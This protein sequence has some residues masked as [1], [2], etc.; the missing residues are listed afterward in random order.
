MA[1]FSGRTQA[2]KRLAKRLGQ[3]GGEVY[4]EISDLLGDPPE[5]MALTPEIWNDI[6]LRY[7]G[8]LRPELEKIFLAALDELLDEISFALDFDMVNAAASD[9]A[10]TYT[11]ELVGGINN[12]SRTMVQQAVADFFDQG[13]SI[14][15]LRDKLSRTFG[16]VRAESIAVTEVTRAV[17]ESGKLMQKELDAQGVRTIPIHNTSND[18]KVCPICLPRD[19]Q[20]IT[21]GRY[22]PL[23]VRCRCWTSYQVI[24]DGE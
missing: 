5:L 18:E 10:R 17:T 15:D 20:P 2:E 8:A 7:T 14:D 4:Q 9:W 13:L 12:T 11:Y 6:Q 22:A 23:H 19:Q 16:P 1:D 21:D 3:L 24:P